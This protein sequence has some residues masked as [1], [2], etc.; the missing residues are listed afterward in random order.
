MVLAVGPLSQD[1]DLGFI[2]NVSNFQ[3]TGMVILLSTSQAQYL[4]EA[5]PVLSQAMVVQQPIV[6]AA[7][8]LRTKLLSFNMRLT[9]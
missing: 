6:S 5:L 9:E 3:A 8:N 4:T 2:S 1:K 7:P